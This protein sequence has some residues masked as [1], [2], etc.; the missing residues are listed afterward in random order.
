MVMFAQ[1]MQDL[2]ALGPNATERFS[3][4]IDEAWIE[5]ALAATESASLRRRKLPADQAIWLVLGMGLF[6][7]RSIDA[8][9]D[10]LGLVVPGTTS[11]ARS[12]IPQARYRL[13]AAPLLWLFRKTADE[14]CAAARKHDYRG[15][16]LFAV[17]G[18]C[19][20]IQDSDENFAHFGKPDGRG[21]D[22]D[23]GYPQLRLACLMSLSEHL[24]VDARFGPYRTSEQE[25]AAQL[26]AQ[27]P[28]KSITILDRGFIHYSVFASLLARGEDRHF[29]V[30]LR[31]NTKPELI[32]L[33]SDGTA[34]ARL[35]PSTTALA[36]EPDLPSQIVGRVVAYKHPDGKPCRLFTT[37][38]D[39]K[40]Y[41]AAELIELYHER[42]EIEIGY[43][44]LKT[45]MLER[46]ECLRSLKPVG[47]EQELWGLLLVYNLVRFELAKA[48]ALVGVLP[49]R[50]SFTHGLICMRSL[51]EFIAWRSTPGVLTRQIAE[52]LSR[53]SLLLLP[54]RRSQRRY[55]RHVKIK[56]SKFPRNR[57]KRLRPSP[58]VEAAENA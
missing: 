31:E 30:R 15:L 55:P 9:V 46:K 1:A 6:A 21:G 5:Q 22:N 39:E 36:K 48:A 4:A 53:C 44:E 27:L 37:L 45:H 12:A 17:D 11:L 58:V 10:H 24:L 32:K 14:W 38:L 56:M 49:K 57:G 23:A 8:V 51:W 3:E 40:T 35:R 42:W 41:P 50:M 18:T 25:L 7:D 16:A 13:G 20:R 33:L 43:D 2:V 47:V 34:I 29:M 19:M 54:E 28:P 52:I 26:W